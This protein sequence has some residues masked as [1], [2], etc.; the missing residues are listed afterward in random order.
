MPLYPRWEGSPRGKGMGWA[1]RLLRGA[2]QDG[3]PVLPRGC[4]QEDSELPSQHGPCLSCSD[5]THSR[6]A[7]EALEL[8]RVPGS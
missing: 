4:R 6:G 3:H 2:I 1:L 5:L 8:F 7:P